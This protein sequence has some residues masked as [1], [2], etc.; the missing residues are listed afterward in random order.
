MPAS[1][2]ICACV[3]ENKWLCQW[4]PNKAIM[5]FFL[6]DSDSI[7]VCVAVLHRNSLTWPPWL[8][9]PSLVRNHCTQDFIQT[10]SRQHPACQACL[11]Q[12]ITTSWKG[13]LI[14]CWLELTWT[15]HVHV[16]LMSESTESAECCTCCRDVDTSY[17]TVQ[18]TCRPYSK[19][20]PQ[21]MQKHS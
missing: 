9:I 8:E 1:I 16:V 4:L 7:F 14:W 20:E 3:E 10:A 11:R 17:Y 6:R 13:L 2:F 15:V 18:T 21:K 12:W 5:L 19:P